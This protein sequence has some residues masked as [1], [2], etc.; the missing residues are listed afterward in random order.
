M[1]D[2]CVEV[3]AGLA[4]SESTE[5]VTGIIGQAL[6]VADFARRQGAS[7][8]RIRLKVG[9]VEVIVTQDTSQK[10]Q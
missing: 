4:S 9:A 7:P 10:K 8:V 3:D 6:E 5:E 2:W 1:E